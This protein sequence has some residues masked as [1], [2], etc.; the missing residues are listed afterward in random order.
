VLLELHHSVADIR[1]AVSQK[2]TK[3]KREKKPQG[4][5]LAS[6]CGEEGENGPSVQCQCGSEVP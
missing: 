2:L 1:V 6:F 5:V 3:T 4:Q